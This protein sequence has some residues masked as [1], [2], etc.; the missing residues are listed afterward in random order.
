LLA[1]LA[2][3][4]LTVN[5]A[6]TVWAFATVAVVFAALLVAA[7]VTV[8]TATTEVLRP[9]RMSGSTVKRW[10]GFV[11][12]FVGAWFI[13]LATLPSPILGS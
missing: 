2:A 5:T 4:S 8:A 3:Q 10:S 7:S 6:Q 1:G 12:L 13:V 9:I 11:L